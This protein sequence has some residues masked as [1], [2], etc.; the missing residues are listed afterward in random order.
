MKSNRTAEIKERNPAIGASVPWPAVLGVVFIIIMFFVS[1][2]AG[3][4]LLSGY[5]S[6]QGMSPAEINASV[7]GSVSAQFIY[8]L[9]TEIIILASLYQFLRFYKRKFKDIGLIRPRWKDVAYGIYAVLPY[10][11][12][13]FIVAATASAIFPG[14]DLNQK[15]QIGFDDV[16]GLIPLGLTFLVLVILQPITE[17]I[18]VR[19]FLYSSLRKAL[20]VILAAIG[21]SLIFASAHLPAGGASGPLFIAGIDTFV[22][23]LFLI[24]LREKTGSLWASITLHSIKNGIAFLTLFIFKVA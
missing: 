15:Q 20:P 17:E 10:Y 8:V 11:L 24:Y 3:G 16:T 9:L 5:Y 4:L 14:L 13:F 6:L 21:T 1:Q 7:T 23:S 22:L 19:G 2:V 12:L 18:M